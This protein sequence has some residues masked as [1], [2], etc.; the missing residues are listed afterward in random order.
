MD[1]GQEITSKNRVWTLMLQTLFFVMRPKGSIY[2]LNFK[3]G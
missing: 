3:K 1:I 2:V